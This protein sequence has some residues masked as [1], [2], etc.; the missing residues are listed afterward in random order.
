MSMDYYIY[1]KRTDEVSIHSFEQYCRS[2]DLC[3]TLHP[4]FDLS[5][6]AGFLP[7]RFT[8]TRF[9]KSSENNTFLSGFEL[10][11]SEYH[12]VSPSQKKETGFFCK[13]FKPKPVEET[14]FDRAVKDATVL[15]ELHCSSADSFEILLAYTFGAYLVKC[16]GGVFDDPQT[17]KFYD[18][19][20][21]LEIEIATI[22]T[23]LQEQAN[24][25]DLLTHEFREWI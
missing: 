7:I 4:S 21:H 15:I 25:G 1:L 12:H 2:L 17:G 6:G 20:K 14:P 3:I 19:S 9:S 16:C 8:D 13:L 23:E 24:T 22:I 10:F 18:E 5:N 11:S